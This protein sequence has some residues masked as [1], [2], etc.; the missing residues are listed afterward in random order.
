MSSKK[1]T[2][3]RVDKVPKRKRARRLPAIEREAADFFAQDG[4][5]PVRERYAY[6][7]AAK[8]VLSRR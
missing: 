4:Q 2:V 3:E 6:Q 8:Q 7:A 5:H 1:S